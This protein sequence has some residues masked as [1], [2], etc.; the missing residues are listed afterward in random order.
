MVSAPRGA[1]P[2]IR[3]GLAIA[4][5]AAIVIGSP[6]VNTARQWLLVTWPEAYVPV[7]AGVVAL[8]ALALLFLAVRAMRDRSWPRIA[9]LA[10][11]VAIAVGSGAALRT[12]VANVD[13]VEAFHFVEYSALTLLFVWAL[14]AP[15][16][17]WAWLWAAY[18]AVLVGAVD[19]WTQWFVPGRTGEIRDVAINGI[20]MTCGLLLAR[21]L[22]LGTGARRGARLWPLGAG[23]AAVL[24]VV[25]GFFA[26]AHLGHEL[27]D[28]ETGPFMSYRTHEELAAL[29]A[30]RARAWGSRGPLGQ[31]QFAREDQYLS[32]ALWHVRRRNEAMDDGDLVAAWRENRILEKYFAPVLR[33][34]TPDGRGHAL[35]GGQVAALAPG[36]AAAAAGRSDANPITIHTWPRAG[37][38]AAVLAAVTVVVFMT[39]RFNIGPAGPRVAEDVHA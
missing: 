36:R 29:S 32:E 21:A 8:T 15:A 16:G 10:L 27:R 35:S 9:A 23:A 2:F 33:I 5:A 30:A 3:L 18:A 28:A 14:A 6:V 11:A 4:A 37:Y 17:E 12:G 31:G 13:V 19:E 7:L 25:A 39:T 1:E 24:L 20:A 22:D 26:S 34:A 38:W